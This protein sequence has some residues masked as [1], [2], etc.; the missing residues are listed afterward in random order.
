MRSTGA[1]RR[2][3]DAWPPAVVLGVADAL[4]LGLVRNLGVR[5]VPIVAVDAHRRA[6][7]FASRYCIAQRITDLHHD[8]AGFV[9]DLIAIGRGRTARPVL[10]TGDEE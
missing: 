8:E 7:G 9:R 10:F 5:G 1:R 3:V 4:G 6:I 2:G